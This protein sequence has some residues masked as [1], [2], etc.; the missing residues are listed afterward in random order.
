MIESFLKVFGLAL[1]T[2]TLLSTAYVVYAV[3]QAKNQQRKSS[4]MLDGDDLEA[5]VDQRNESS[6]GAMGVQMQKALAVQVLKPSDASDI[7]K[8]YFVPLPIKQVRTWNLEPGK[9]LF[10]LDAGRKRRTSV[11]QLTE[12]WNRPT[13]YA[14]RRAQRNVVSLEANLVGKS[15]DLQKY[16]DRILGASKLRSGRSGEN[17]LER[18][19]AMPY[20][21][22]TTH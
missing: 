12:S 17:V 18:S 6:F 13:I 10:E 15:T 5:R 4:E 11:G 8:E 20:G 2:A 7:F 21:E 22:K 9:E 19:I 1:S 14:L 3:K 16:R